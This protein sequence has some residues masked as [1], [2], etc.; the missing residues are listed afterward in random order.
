MVDFP[1]MSVERV[2]DSN[3]VYLLMYL[4]GETIQIYY[5]K[6]FTLQEYQNTPAPASFILL[7]NLS[8]SEWD[9]I[10]LHL[11]DIATK[12]LNELGVYK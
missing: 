11:I 7:G 8:V 3:W 6:P 12:K 1:F 10:G 5:S 9:G 2:T 4:N